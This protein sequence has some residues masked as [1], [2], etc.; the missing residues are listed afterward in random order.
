MLQN[1]PRSDNTDSR[2]LS[3]YDPI[4]RDI[5]T[6]SALRYVFEESKRPLLRRSLSL[7]IHLR[8]SFPIDTFQGSEIPLDQ[9][10]LTPES[11]SGF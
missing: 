5:F 1:S 11:L 6:P 2:S 4:Q 7:D 9:A 3:A 10:K 8:G